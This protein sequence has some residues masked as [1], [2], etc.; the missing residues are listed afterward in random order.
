MG[1]LFSFK[2]NSIPDN[3]LVGAVRG[4]SKSVETVL[5]ACRE[6]TKRQRLHFGKSLTDYSQSELAD[7]C[8]VVVFDCLGKF[9]LDSG[10]PFSAYVHQ[11]VRNKFIS[12][13]NDSRRFVSIDQGWND[14]GTECP[15]ISSLEWE[16]E[17]SVS[18]SEDRQ[19]ASLMLST[20]FT[21]TPDVTQ[22][23]S[24]LLVLMLE[25]FR[26]G[27]TPTNQMLA[28]RLGISHQA[29]S[30]TKNKAFRKFRETG[31]RLKRQWNMAV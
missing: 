5:A 8:D 16:S 1:K 17:Y 19:H 6:L 26:N 11:A 27:V 4:D 14:G 24:R 21:R 22:A 7:I 28:E 13:R 2:E 15:D 12:M 18:R 10:C 20:L 31:A 25:F 30:K 29:A 9:R 3:M 23:E